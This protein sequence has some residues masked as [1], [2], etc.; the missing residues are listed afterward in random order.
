MR[1]LED[2][3]RSI[4][5][6]VRAQEGE[7]GSAL[8]YALVIALVVVI[9][10]L[11]LSSRTLNSIFGAVFQQDTRRAR[12]AAEFGINRI[13]AELNRE[14]NRGLLAA[15]ISSTAGFWTQADADA[16]PNR[17]AELATPARISQP[18]LNRIRSGG[19]SGSFG[20]KN[21]IVYVS[22]DGSLAAELDNSPD[23]SRASSVRY[24]YQLVD[25]PGESIVLSE[26][27]AGADKDP[28]SPTVGQLN[29]LGSI[30][31]RVRG[32]SYNNGRL[33]GS[34]TV[35]ETLEVV[36]KCCGRSLAKFGNDLRSC[37]V[38]VGPGL[39]FLIGVGELTVGDAALKGSKSELDDGTTPINPIVCISNRTDNSDCPGSAVTI[40]RNL[41]PVVPVPKPSGF[42]E[43]E[44]FPP[45]LGTPTAGILQPCTK[46]GLNISCPSNK[47]VS[48]PSETTD[49][50]TTFTSFDSASR[51][52][53]VHIDTVLSSNLPDWCKEESS[54]SG[55]VT[56]I[57]C[58][59]SR[60]SLTGNINIRTTNSR[61]LKLYFPQE[62]NIITSTGSAFLR[63]DNRSTSPTDAGSVLQLQIFGCRESPTGGCSGDSSVINTQ[64]ITLNGNSTTAIQD[65]YFLYAPIASI[66]INGGG[67]TPDQ[68]SGILW[69]N[70]VTG[71][72]NVE[73]NVP[74][75]GVTSILSQYGMIDKT[76][77]G[78]DKPIIWDYV[79]RAVRQFRLLPGS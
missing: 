79:T 64:N 24:A 2:P 40:G 48:T 31:L 57:H 45:S 29:K 59:V 6:Q 46:A 15:K 27:T 76:N 36:P 58:N 17:C 25:K 43:V 62:G 22:D 35:E 63:H 56:T 66:T 41:V 3:T 53:T 52:T 4:V 23:Q 50:S 13:I 68:F 10:G 67:G 54:S 65:P 1:R 47:V 49:S 18:D 44:I 32:F 33:T 38:N 20:N 70:K 9:S 72:G 69:G 11:A 51:T 7:Q 5:G 26:P 34:V 21:P 74:G 75:S 14:S 78:N 73:I 61:R 42:P 37:T 12:E 19:V 8:A 39:G 60:L 71:N 30:Q 28:A 55:G 77:T 16:N